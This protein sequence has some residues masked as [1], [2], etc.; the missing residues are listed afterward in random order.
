MSFILGLLTEEDVVGCGKDVSVSFGACFAEEVLRSF[1]HV[2]S[3]SLTATRRRGC[4]CV[5]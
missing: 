2:Q 5:D 4:A 1:S 3:V